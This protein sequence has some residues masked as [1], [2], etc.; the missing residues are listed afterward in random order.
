MKS[1][2]AGSTQLPLSLNVNAKP[3]LTPH[4]TCNKKP[5]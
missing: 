1:H 5:N 4:K 3:L 2:T